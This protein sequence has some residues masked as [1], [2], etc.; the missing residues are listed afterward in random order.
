M[1]D[2]LTRRKEGY[3]LKL[4]KAVMAADSDSHASIH[5]Q[6][7]T[8]EE[9][10]S[11]YL[12]E[13]WYLK[14]CFIDHFFTLDVDLEALHSAKFGVEGDFVLEPYKYQLLPGSRRVVMSRD[15]HLWRPQGKI[16]MHVTKEFTFDPRHDQIEVKLR[17]FVETSGR[18]RCQLRDREQL[19]LPGRSRRGPFRDGRQSPR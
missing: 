6:V 8:K 7:L 5:D 18:S 4:D 19:Q 9:G 13:D 11:R 16:D 10:L 2:T 14:R 15:G 1:T 3:H 17:P 12:V